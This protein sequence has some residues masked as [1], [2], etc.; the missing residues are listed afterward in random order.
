MSFSTSATNG[1]SGLGSGF[2]LNLLNFDSA[3]DEVD[4]TEDD[5]F[6]SSLSFAFSDIL[7]SIQSQI[8]LFKSQQVSGAAAAPSEDPALPDN[9]T[10]PNAKTLKVYSDLPAV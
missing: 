9:F 10:F 7:S 1:L 8:S 6:N 2:N 4:E 3:V 5:G